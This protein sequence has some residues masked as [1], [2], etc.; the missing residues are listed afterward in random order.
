MLR[1][2][3]NVLRCLNKMT[4]ISSVGLIIF[5]LNL[6]RSRRFF[7]LHYYCWFPLFFLLNSNDVAFFKSTHIIMSLLYFSFSLTLMISGLMIFGFS[8]KSVVGN[9]DL[10]RLLIRICDGDPMSSI[11][12]LRYSSMPKYG[13]VLS[14]CDFSRILFT[15]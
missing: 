13:S 4:S 11:G 12:V 5:S 6:V 7:F 1:I 8:C 9:N 15:I 2:S 10:R 14:R 3:D